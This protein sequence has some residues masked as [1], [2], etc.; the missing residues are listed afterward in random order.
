[1]VKRLAAG[2]VQAAARRVERVTPPHG[3]NRQ[4]L[5]IFIV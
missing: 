2:A 5:F 1:V 4:D 3:K